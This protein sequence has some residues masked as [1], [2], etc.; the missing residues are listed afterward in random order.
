[1]TATPTMA[2]GEREELAKL[3]RAQARVAKTM[4]KEREAQLIADAEA[5]LAKQYRIDDPIWED[6]TSEAEAE[7]G[8]FQKELEQR[9]EAVGIPKEFAPRLSLHWYSRGENGMRERRAEHRSVIRTRLAA[10]GKEACSAIERRTLE[11]LTLLA[12]DGLASNA[13]KAFLATMPKIDT[14]MPPV[15]LTA[16]PFTPTDR[17]SY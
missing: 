14:L 1:M 9:I 2:K 6:L 10:M 12:M 13:A 5:Q 4:A 16:I 17:H 7:M 11:G 8:R 15:D 3:L